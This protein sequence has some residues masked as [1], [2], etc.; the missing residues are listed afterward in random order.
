M[1]LISDKDR[2]NK[3]SRKDRGDLKHTIDYS[4]KTTGHNLREKEEK[5]SLKRAE[6]FKSNDSN[7]HP[8]LGFF[9]DGEVNQVT[10]LLTLN[11]GESLINIHFS[12][13]STVGTNIYEL[14]W[15]YSPPEDLTFTTDSGRI[16]AVSG[17]RTVRIIAGTLSSTETGSLIGI[18]GS[19]TLEKTDL[20]GSNPFMS[21]FHNVSQSVY[22]YYVPSRVG[23]DVTFAKT[24]FS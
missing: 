12:H 15:S 13:Y 4:T 14:H 17:G 11:P 24:K 19:V 10:H 8:T 23:T 6:N 9:K 1:P 2:Y 21:I 5:V 3:I 20:G 18:L 22:F 16:T 7:L